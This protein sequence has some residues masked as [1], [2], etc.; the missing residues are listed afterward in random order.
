R[1]MEIDALLG[2]VKE[3]GQLAGVATPVIDLV[4]ALV[5]QRARVAG[6]YQVV[7]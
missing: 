2:A 3:L 5:R 6:C 7:I 4:L 1:T